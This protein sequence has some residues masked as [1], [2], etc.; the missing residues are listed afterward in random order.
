MMHIDEDGNVAPGPN[1]IPVPQ[2]DRK[3]RPEKVR[4]V[5]DGPPSAKSGR[6]VEVETMDGKSIDLGKW[7][8]GKNGLWYLEFYALM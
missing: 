1:M 8:K 3:L 5:F 4:V 7:V 2:F 6:F